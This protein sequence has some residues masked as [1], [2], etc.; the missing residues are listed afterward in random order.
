MELS[1]QRCV[2]IVTMARRSTHT[3]RGALGAATADASLM[4]RADAA[5]QRL[6]RELVASRIA[7]GTVSEVNRLIACDVVAFAARTSECGHSPDC[8]LH[9][10]QTAVAVKAVLGNRGPRLPGLTV[11]D[12]DNPAVRVLQEQR[13]VSHPDLADAALCPE[14][15]A[16]LEAEEGIASL[17]A[18]PVAF[19]GEVRAVVLVGLRRTGGLSE[20]VSEAVARVCTYAGAAMAAA[21]DRARVEE[22]AAQRE[23]RRLARALHDELGQ[24]LFGIGILVGSALKGATAGRPDLLTQLENLTREVAGASTA[25]RRTLN[26]LDTPPTPAGALA[27]KLRED[28]AAFRERSGLPAH[29]VVL[30]EEMPVD[31]DGADALVRV[32]QEGLRNADRHARAREV[33]VTL[34]FDADAVEVAV[35]DDGV[36]VRA[37]TVAG[38]GVGS[39][40]EEITRLGGE[41]TLSRGD[42]TGSVL[43]ARIPWRG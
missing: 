8:A 38:F 23:R 5:G 7:W 41:V 24:R 43:R 29:L 22:I 1:H 3:A 33:V 42:D 12:P 15:R 30:G 6:F 40:G 4:R 16:V 25:F 34:A 28:T 17:T 18:V 36:G 32:V 35:H 39:L 26:N 14:V 13:T 31:G 37:G 19:G 2:T 11:S 20:Q 10:C 21:R 9:H 27:V